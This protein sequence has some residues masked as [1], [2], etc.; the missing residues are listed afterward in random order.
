MS[1]KLLK[2]IIL[3]GVIFLAAGQVYGM[4]D[5]LSADTSISPQAVK[6]MIKYNAADS[7]RFDVPAQKVFLFGN[8]EVKYEDITLK[9]AYVEVNWAE[10]L[11]Y[12]EGRTDSSGKVYG[13]PVFDE[14]GESFKASSIRYNFGTKKG[15]ITSVITHE[16]DG[17]IHGETVKKDTGSVFYIKNGVY[18]TCDLDTP[19]FYIGASRLKVIQH[20]K[21]VTGPAYLVVENVPTPLAVPFG[22]FPNRRG[23]SSG[24]LIPAYGESGSLGFFLQNGGYYFGINDYMDM[25]VRGD[26][27]S[28]GSWGVKTASA[29]SR[30][31]HYQGAVALSFSE[32]K[33]GEKELPGYS[34]NRNFFV[35]W[36]HAQDA[37]SSPGSRFSAN[38]NAGSSSYFRNNVSVSSSDYLSNT[39]QSAVAY[40][41][42][43]KFSNLSLNLRHA[44]NTLN[45]TVS[46][47][48]PEVAYNVNRFYPFRSAVRAGDEKWYEKIAVTYSASSQNTIQ[49]ADSLLFNKASLA[50]F[51]NGIRHSV[52]VSASFNMLKYLSFT[53][54]LNFTER[55][56]FQKTKKMWDAQK[57]SLI[58]DTLDVPGRVGDFITSASFNTRIYGMYQFGNSYIKAIRHVM[59]P[60]VAFSWRPD[61]SRSSWGYYD[62]VQ[63]DK[64]G[65]MALYSYFEKGIY[66]TAPSGKSGVVSFSLDNN[67]EMKVRN[68]ADTLT[69]MKKIKILDAFSIAS[70]YNMAADSLRW[71]PFS[72]SGRTTLFNRVNI[73]MSSGIDP[74]AADSSGRR[75][76]NFEWKEHGRI[77]RLTRAA[78]ALNFNL[79]HAS[80]NKSSSKGTEQEMKMINASPDAY[81]DFNIPWNIAL[82]YTLNYNKSYGTVIQSKE[83]TQSLGFNGDLRITPRWKVGFNSGY[84][85]INKDFS[86]TSLNIY[87]DLHCWEMKFN[88]IPFG[89]HRSYNFQVN[90]KSPVLQD[91]KL[92]RKRDW[93]DT[94]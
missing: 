2:I 88:L 90:V 4:P 40:S 68:D 16:G 50:R 18:T 38:V 52:P 20:D 70:S 82:S 7:I 39:F 79:N 46:L 69:G 92:M 9:A 19:H 89:P 49:T 44:Q 62:S 83:T 77:G 53:P 13:T 93:Y 11:L 74:Y 5:S 29:Y 64:N 34:L 21:I 37:K 26:V 76:N 66:G 94:Q 3:P 6:S 63:T 25:A 35:R 48:L 14:K 65:G 28:R 73:T 1:A 27:Y 42:T 22:F 47:S 15:K 59:S 17:Y 51:Q 23:R 36:N 78:M 87:R 91:L 12:A 55:W 85:F 43:W 31:Y 10:K 45:R 8:A 56:Y 84:D 30:R 72:V 24:I 80:G 71:A 41:R 75:H 57:D 58:T 86:Y 67:L 60:S 33:T 61:F 32:I 81:I 54:S